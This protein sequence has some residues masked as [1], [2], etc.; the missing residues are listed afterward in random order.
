MRMDFAD[1]A[2][3]IYLDAGL[4]CLRKDCAVAKQASRDDHREESSDLGSHKCFLYLVIGCVSQNR[5]ATVLWN[6][7]GCAR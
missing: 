7:G 1:G 2:V 6:D 5:H 3:G 4:R